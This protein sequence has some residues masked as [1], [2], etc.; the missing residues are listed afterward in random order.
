MQFLTVDN[1]NAHVLPGCVALN[2]MRFMSELLAAPC[3]ALTAPIS[4]DQTS[5]SGSKRR[6]GDPLKQA[7]SG[8]FNRVRIALDCGRPLP[9]RRARRCRV[10][11]SAVRVQQVLAVMPLRRIVVDG[12]R[13]ML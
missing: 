4:V 7:R 2:S 12:H 3:C 10:R 5:T 8:P 1:R 6:L 13:R 11:G 9:V